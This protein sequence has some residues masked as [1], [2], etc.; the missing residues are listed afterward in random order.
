MRLLSAMMFHLRA[1]SVTDTYLMDCGVNH[2]LKLSR[3]VKPVPLL[4]DRQA[5]RPHCTVATAKWMNLVCMS[6]FSMGP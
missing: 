5:Q 6:V 2:I 4:Q 1:N 3:A